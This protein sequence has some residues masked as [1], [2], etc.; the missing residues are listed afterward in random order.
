MSVSNNFSQPRSSSS[1]Q[2]QEEPRSKMGNMEKT[3]FSREQSDLNRMKGIF[4]DDDDED[5][6]LFQTS[7]TSKPIVDNNLFDNIE[8]DDLFGSTTAVEKANH[9]IFEEKG[10]NILFSKSTVPAVEEDRVSSIDRLKQQDSVSM[11]SSRSSLFDDIN[12]GK[13]NLASVFDNDKSVKN[14]K[15]LFGETDDNLFSENKT[16]NFDE[17]DPDDLFSDNVIIKSKQNNKNNMKNLFDDLEDAD[18]LFGD[19]VSKKLFTNGDEESLFGKPSEKESV[20]NVSDNLLN[21]KM[22]SNAS[23]EN[24]VGSISESTDNLFDDVFSETKY[25]KSSEDGF[26]PKTPVVS[27]FGESEEE[28]DD[29]FSDT[30]PKN[31]SVSKTIKNESMEKLE[32]DDGDAFKI[33]KREA[34]EH[35]SN[36]SG[37][38]Y[39][40][41]KLDEALNSLNLIDKNDDNALFDEADKLSMNK[42]F[43]KNNNE[44]NDLFENRTSKSHALENKSLFEGDDNSLFSNKVH[45]NRLLSDKGED[46][47]R[48]L[49]PNTLNI[50][51]KINLENQDSTEADGTINMEKAKVVGKLSIPPSLNINPMRLLPG[52]IAKKNIP[53]E[54]SSPPEEP[55]QA[56]KEVSFNTEVS[57]NLLKCVNKDRVKIQMR[58]R[59]QTRRARHE[60]LR[61]SGID[62]QAGISEVSASRSRSADDF[63]SEGTLSPTIKS[64][65]DTNVSNSVL[66]NSVGEP[67]SK[68]TDKSSSIFH[69]VE[70]SP[71]PLFS[72]PLVSN[73]LSPSTDEEDYFNV[74]ELDVN[75]ERED[76]SIFKSNLSDS[77]ADDKSDDTLLFDGAPVLSPM[78]QSKSLVSDRSTIDTVKQTMRSSVVNVTEKLLKNRIIDDD[79]DDDDNLFRAAEP[80]TEIFEEKKK[81]GKSKTDNLFDDLDDGD[82]FL[83]QKGADTAGKKEFA[84]KALF[85]DNDEDDDL[86]GEKSVPTGSLSGILDY[87]TAKTKVNKPIAE[88][89]KQS[90]VDPLG[91]MANP[92]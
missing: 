92:D 33:F 3:H 29:L 15:D 34:T 57:T 52:A 89:P 9:P 17:H 69:S 64:I 12:T 27:I 6:D 23:P 79:D 84:K 76:Q 61:T 42:S 87:T 7:K 41:G 49:P 71:E 66:V 11:S 24:A 35:S 53:A 40:V 67:D 28:D 51:K 55:Q 38:K 8:N 72:S 58:R 37:E 14:S 46:G 82:S 74:P 60:A 25:E 63:E 59:P 2:N 22:E 68:T 90:F 43:N 65:S 47:I 32:D 88:K 26:R 54:A 48:P 1:I 56:E 36:E 91:L 44:I 21:K 86:F 10:D 62:F 75:F 83:F 20:K 78:D 73:P 50:V 39:C 13:T 19:D 80:T 85:D 31:N 16:S 18:D 4:G 5:D 77:Q 45:E 30:K 70:N 81:E